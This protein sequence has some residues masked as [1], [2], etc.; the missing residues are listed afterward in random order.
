[1]LSLSDLE[2]LL[3]YKDGD[4]DAHFI[5]RA[6]DGDGRLQIAENRNTV[7]QGATGLHRVR[8]KIA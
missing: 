8:A 2:M 7:P 6:T 4:G 3:A 5:V 1:M